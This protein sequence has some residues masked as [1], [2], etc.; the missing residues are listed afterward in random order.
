MC[1]RYFRQLALLLSILLFSG[2]GQQRVTA[3]TSVDTPPDNVLATVDGE[4]ISEDD[5]T[6][7]ITRTLGEYA[8]FQLDETGRDKVLQSLVL[9]KA[10]AIKQKSLMS[11]QENSEVERMVN[12]YREE[13]LAK[14]Y[15]QDNV[16][17]LPVTNAMVKKYY[18][19]KPEKFGGKTIK[20]FEVVKGLIT[21]KGAARDETIE[22]ISQLDQQDDWQLVASQLK[23]QGIQIDYSQGAVTAGVLTTEIDKIIQHLSVNQSS[24]LRFVQGL[25]IKVRVL[26]QKT[27]APKPLMAVA[28]TIKKSLAP[29]QLKK[30]VN[31]E[32]T[33]LLK[34]VTVVYKNQNKNKS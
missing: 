24:E 7:A 12:A 4:V 23:T 13:L 20:T 11:P 25:P 21:S 6:A 34:Q 18:Q 31:K 9:S 27:I 17:A 29:I 30:A 22:H 16:V 32:A 33:K 1:N 19:Q 5:L 3:E 2:C 14:R 8:A 26:E 15:L 10:M 28:S